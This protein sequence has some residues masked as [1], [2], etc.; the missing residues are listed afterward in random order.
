[1]APL[2]PGADPS[3]SV[4]TVTRMRSFHDASGAVRSLREGVCALNKGLK[5]TSVKKALM[6]H[7]TERSRHVAENVSTTSSCGNYLDD[8]SFDL[9]T[10]CI[11]VINIAG[12][13]VQ[14]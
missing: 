10:P 9:K 13:S 3:E 4:S 5:K 8:Q 11:V 14:R 7:Q 6:F 2:Y 12:G 1:M